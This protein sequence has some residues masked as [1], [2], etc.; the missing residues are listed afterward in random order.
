MSLF[1]VWLGLGELA[2]ALLL[3]LAH[4]LRDHALAPRLAAWLYGSQRIPVP[5][6]HLWWTAQPRR[7]RFWLGVTVFS[8]A[9]AVACAWIISPPAGFWLVAVA[10]V[11]AEYNI[12]RPRR[13]IPEE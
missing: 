2:V 13:N 6:H 12:F 10:E 3:L 4:Y 9:G 7:A 5:P 11:A 8:G 1:W